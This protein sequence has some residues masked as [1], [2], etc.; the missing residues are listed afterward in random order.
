[1]SAYTYKQH[2]N[3]ELKK[4][5]G[6]MGAVFAFAIIGSIAAYFVTDDEFGNKLFGTWMLLAEIAVG[7]RF[8][9]FPVTGEK[10]PLT[11]KKSSPLLLVICGIGIGFLCGFQGTGGG[12]L[13][14]IALTSFGR[15]GFKQAVGTSVFIMTFTALIGAASHFIINGWPD[16][17]MLVTCI[18]STFVFARL[19]ANTANRITVK[20]LNLITGWLLLGTGILLAIFENI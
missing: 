5:S 8:L 6:L 16:M 1:V 18:I 17:S 20:Q 11:V 19:A 14:L 13:L 4:A 7:L 12:M 2:G 10:D 15:Y 3:I 9:I